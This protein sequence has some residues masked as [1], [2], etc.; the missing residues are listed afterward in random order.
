MKR[1][2]TGNHGQIGHSLVQQLT[3]KHIDIFAVDRQQLNITDQQTVFNTVKQYQPDVI[4]NTA[5]DKAEN[6]R[7]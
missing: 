2:I 5:V 6:E 3:E 1:L 7:N 4:I